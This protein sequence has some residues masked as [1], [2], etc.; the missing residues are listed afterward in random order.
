MTMRTGFLGFLLLVSV[1]IGAE[2]PAGAPLANTKQELQTLRKEQA[3]KAGEI[4]GGKLPGSGLQ[5]QAPNAESVP[6]DYSKKEKKDRAQ[7]E[8]NARQKNWLVDGVNELEKSDKR[9]DGSKQP[10][11]SEPVMLDGG[12]EPKPEPS[13]P[14]YLL[15]VYNEQ[16]KE[17]EAKA[18]LKVQGGARNDPIAPFLQ[19]WLSS[20]PA[21]GKFSDEFAHKSGGEAATSVATGP[22]S[23]TYQSSPYSGVEAGAG[24]RTISGQQANPYLQDPD[25]P[26][27]LQDLGNGRSSVPM[28]A[29][30]FAKPAD[31][32]ATTRLADPLPEYRATEKKP[33]L[34]PQAEDKKYFPQLKKF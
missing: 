32:P 26:R 3:A 20:S 31:L 24:G 29:G 34:P 27:L 5:I 13:D 9:K 4:N 11:E 1:A 22:A 18:D 8:K 19:G 14:D 33:L 15:K 6:F 28:D 2:E 23:V 17:S 7:Q 12:K 21:Q 16:K 25:Q 30:S 10:I